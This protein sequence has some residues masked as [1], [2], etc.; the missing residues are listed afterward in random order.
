[1]AANAADMIPASEVERI[2]ASRVE[3]EINKHLERIRNAPQSDNPAWMQEL[4]MSIAALSDQGSG[5]RRVAPDEMA[6]RAEGYASMLALLE[7]ANREQ[8]E[9]VYKLRHVVYLG[10]LRVNPIWIDRERRQQPTE[11]GWYG[12][13]NEAMVPINPVA[14]RIY[15]AFLQWIGAT[16]VRDLGPMRVTASGLAV[17][18]RGPPS[19]MNPEPRHVAGHSADGPLAPVIRGRGVQ[20]PGTETHILGT[21]MPPAR[22][23]Y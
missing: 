20:G 18:K 13:P 19:L 23:S 21:V 7:Q 15:A 5:R 3:D 8:D 10:E 11:I 22:Q 16:A 12:V 17:I 2:I 9:P 4:A 1:M 14:E 6:R